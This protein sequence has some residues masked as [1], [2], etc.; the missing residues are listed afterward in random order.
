MEFGK[1]S[2]LKV[3]A[4][5]QNKYQKLDEVLR[6]NS[7]IVRLAH[8]DFTQWLSES[9]NGRRS[10]FT[11]EEILRSLMVMF[12]EGDSYR[13]V[14]IRIDGSW[15]LRQFVGLGPCRAMM[16]YSF[17]S[18]AM[19]A[20][21]PETVAQINRAVAQQAREEEKISGEKLRGDT[22]VYEIAIHYPT[23]SSL[24]LD[25]YRVLAR[26][27]KAI[28]RHLEG[29][30]VRHRFHVKKARRRAMF[31]A[32]HA[33]SK[34]KKRQRQVKRTYKELMGQVRWISCVC[35]EIREN[36]EPGSP[37]DLLLA[38]Y[39]RLA[40]RVIYQAEKRILEGVRVPATEKVYSIFEEHTELIK[41]GKAGKDV[42]FGHK[43]ML[44]QTEQKFI[45]Q[46]EVYE[47]RQEDGTLVKAMLKEHRSLFDS[48]PDTLCL[49]QG[50][51][52]N[53]GQLRDL[54]ET[55]PT[56]SIRKKGRSTREDQAY[57]SS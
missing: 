19:S 49:D 30:S 38:H 8:G 55:I 51:Y 18:R 56:V 3:V 32:R 27:L 12:L 50:F 31:I 24:L 1:K 23:D 54:K 41:R 14:V 7:E 9:W 34:N 11:T 40:S 6:Q 22:T 35:G 45:S 44:G 28:Q 15:F 21:Q 52:G 57:E 2:N 17:L 47:R 37:E 53:L 20:L 46:Y 29:L 16:D 13:D 39:Q 26:E 5:W 10:K 43:I 25:C 48:V 4:E 36:L 33:K 42:E